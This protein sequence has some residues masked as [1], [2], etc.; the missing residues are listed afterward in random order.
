MFG[1]IYPSERARVPAAVLRELMS[2]LERELTR[3]STDRV[4]QGTLISRAQY[5]VDVGHWD[6]ADPRLAPRGNMTSAECVRWTAGI[7]NDG[8]GG[9]PAPAVDQTRAA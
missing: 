5:L 8:P 6:Y 3:S 2:R 4:C 9:T 1:F 7:A